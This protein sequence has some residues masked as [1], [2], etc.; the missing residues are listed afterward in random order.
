M[1]TKEDQTTNS[2]EDLCKCFLGLN[3]LESKLFSIVLHEP[4][5]TCKELS[6]RVNQ[7]RTPVQRALKGLFEKGWLNRRNVS[8]EDNNTLLF[9][10][11]PLDPTLLKKHLLELVDQ[12]RNEML[13][14][15]NTSF[16]PS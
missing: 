8:I 14:I 15:I 1:L 7:T 4:G 3:A 2:L 13:R 6:S 10:Y 11:Y 9:R 12:A 5:L 16:P